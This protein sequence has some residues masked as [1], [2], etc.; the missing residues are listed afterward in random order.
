MSPRR[1]R[2]GRE[3]RRG[4]ARAERW[5]GTAG[6]ALACRWCGAAAASLFE[7]SLSASA[8]SWLAVRGPRLSHHQQ[9]TVWIRSA[10]DDWRHGRHGGLRPRRRATTSMGCHWEPRGRRCWPLDLGPQAESGDEALRERPPSPHMK[11]SSA[12]SNDLYFAAFSWFVSICSACARGRGRNDHPPS[13]SDRAGGA[14]SPAHQPGR[15]LLQAAARNQGQCIAS[16]AAGLRARRHQPVVRPQ[17]LLPLPLPL[18]LELLLLPLPLLRLALRLQ[19][20]KVGMVA[21][22]R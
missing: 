14:A 9:Q 21:A 22:Q 20:R 16:R 2:R 12:S 18:L 19:L 3:R 6:R 5:R 17:L 7:C 13:L 15:R 4:R 10:T 11:S 1:R 8:A